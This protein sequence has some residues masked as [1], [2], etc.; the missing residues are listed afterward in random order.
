M[1]YVN[2]R[3]LFSR[4]SWNLEIPDNTSMM[5]NEGRH[6]DT[7]NGFAGPLGINTIL[8]MAMDTVQAAN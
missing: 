7:H 3:T 8:T 6:D 5:D 4:M 2:I 1:Y